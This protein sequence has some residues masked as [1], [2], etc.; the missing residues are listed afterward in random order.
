MGSQ[1]FFDKNL[2]S[3]PLPPNFVLGNDSFEC[4]REEPLQ[5][6]IGRVYPCRR[7]CDGSEVAVKVIV[8]QDWRLL[9]DAYEYAQNARHPN[10]AQIYDIYYHTTALTTF[11]FITMPFYSQEI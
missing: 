6:G 7:V 10:I 4:T 5:G 1:I 9:I 2:S 3:L 11:L 8:H